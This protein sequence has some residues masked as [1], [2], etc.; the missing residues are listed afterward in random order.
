M[1]EA[2]LYT[3]RALHPLGAVVRFPSHGGI[4]GFRPPSVPGGNVTQFAPHKALRLIA[5]GK[6]TF[7]ERVAL[8]CVDN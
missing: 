5:R 8:H 4:R 6:L 2:S 1:S 3:A 7:D